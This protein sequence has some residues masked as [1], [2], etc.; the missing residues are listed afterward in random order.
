M[1][2]KRIQLLG[3][4]E[5]VLARN[6]FSVI[7]TTGNEWIVFDLIAKD[8]ERRFILKVLYN[9]DTLKPVTAFQMIKLSRLLRASATIIGERAGGGKL[10]HGVVYYRHGVPIS[11]IET[12]RDYLEGDE[13]Y[14]YSGPGGFY[15]HI[16]GEAIKRK[17]SE[18]RLS[19]GNISSYLGVSR[20]SVS[21]YENGSA[22]T[23]D[24]FSK[25]QNLLKA[26]IISPVDLFTIDSKISIPDEIVTD[27]YLVRI[28][29]LFI[30]FG[31][32]SHPLLKTPFDVVA[33]DDPVYTFLVSLIQGSDDLQKVRIVKK[34]SDAF[35]DDAIFISRH[36]TQKEKIG[37][38]ALFNIRE[39]EEIGTKERFVKIIEKRAK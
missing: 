23:I 5:S 25:L 34:I 20:R 11:S 6:G 19:I 12:F 31:I 1:E 33:R 35:N 14:V 18:V 32:E 16:D 4:T 2:D 26:N 37:G 13:P 8:E 10:E 9:V 3:Q 21:L 22:A 24:I 27:E 38:C 17:R 28:L 7:R 29:D 36:D 15:V 39:L 30:N